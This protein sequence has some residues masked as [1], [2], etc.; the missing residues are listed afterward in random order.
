MH[1]YFE[2]TWKKMVLPCTN[3]VF[4]LGIVVLWKVLKCI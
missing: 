1:L 4:T 2:K 3:L